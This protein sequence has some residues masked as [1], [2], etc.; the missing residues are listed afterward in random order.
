[1]RGGTSRAF[2]STRLT[3]RPIRL[4]AIGVL[5]RVMGSPDPY[6]KQIDG[7]GAATSSTSKIVI[8]SKSERPD[9]DIDYLFGQVAIDRPMVDWSGSCGNLI[10]AVGP[11]AIS[12]GLF[13][14]PDNGIATVRIWQV[15]LSKKIVAYV[16]VQDGDVRED[17]DFEI[18]GVAFPGAEIKI[19]FLD[20]GG[21]ED[22]GDGGEMFPT[23]NVVDRLDV[24]SLG[25]VNV[26]MIN[27]GM[28]TIFIDASTLNL[29][30]TEMQPDIDSRPDL[31]R[32]METVRAHC[33]VAMG[34][35]E[36][37]RGRQRPTARIRRS[38]RSSRRRRA[39]NPRPA[40][41]SRPTVSISPRASS[42]WVG[43]ITP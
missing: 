5:L 35:G 34:F 25:P 41:I 18:D 20:P 29:K 2:S 38:C 39:T 13:P 24:P 27:A 3:C 6:G 8:I 1:M 33:A 9:C 15:N 7:M 28:P 36:E 17:G 30:G 14:A 23:G 19:D 26:T 43:C 10:S 42:R 31:M 12:E 40:S 4:H 22:G 21:A 16:P 37:P 11:F 32:T